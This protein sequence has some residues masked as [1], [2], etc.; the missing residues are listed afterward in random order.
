MDTYLMGNVEVSF[1]NN[2]L[3][4]KQ[5]FFSLIENLNLYGSH[6]PIHIDYYKYSPTF[7]LFFGIFAFLPVPVGLYLWNL[8]NATVF[9]AIWR[10]KFPHVKNKFW[11]WLFLVVEF[12]TSIQ[13]SQSNGLMAGLMILAFVF[14]E[15][16]NVAIATL[17]I[18]LSMFIKIFGVVA[19]ALFLF[20]PD[21]M[22]AIGYAIFWGVL[23]FVLPLLVVSPNE[24]LAQYEN[25]WVLL[26]NDKPVEFSLSVMGWLKYWF[27]FIPSG[28]AL[29][30][31]GVVLFLIPLTQIK[32]YSNPVFRELILAS[33][34]MWV[35]L[36]N[37]K[38]ESPTFIIS[39]AGVAI[40]YFSQPKSTW[41]TVLLISTILF[42]QLAP[43]DLYPKS[44]R[45]SFFIPYVIKVFPIILVWLK[46]L[47]DALF[48][49]NEISET[50]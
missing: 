16:K 3:I 33:V 37:H 25:W 26:K 29:T 7:A 17:M 14:L 13:S 5:S 22:K 11:V 46:L 28:G 39:I 43:T 48:L 12:I 10:I 36:F 19:F 40:W 50:I 1:Y 27:G 6:R 47:Y 31:V 44:I 41:N 9:Y 32:K 4:F 45:E 30:G 42:T 34:L 18:V 20:Y 21:K 2:Y 24:L 38:A 35:V 23:L 15:R 49:K 8:L